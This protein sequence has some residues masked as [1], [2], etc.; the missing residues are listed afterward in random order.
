MTIYTGYIYLWYDTRAK[1]FYL[2]GHKGKVEDSYV[3]SNKMML[4]AYRKRPE[5][6][7]LK[8]LEYVNGDNKVLREAEQRWLNLIHDKELYW[9]PNIYNKTVKYYNQKK[10]SSGGNGS[11]NKGKSRTAW[12]KGLKLD[13]PAWNKGQRGIK[14]HSDDTR[15]LMSAKKQ[16]YWDTCSKRRPLHIFN[17]PIC[18]SEIQTRNQNKK[19]CSNACKN[20]LRYGGAVY[21]T[22]YSTKTPNYLD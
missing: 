20:K 10:H 3:C 19:T 2:G 22:E 17:C 4:R 1:L 9:T 12:N 14:P 18:N 13:R 15:K 16:E 6:F 11:A 8:I 7:K 5:T 21:L